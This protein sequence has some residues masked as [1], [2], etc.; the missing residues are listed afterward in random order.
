MDI[1]CGVFLRLPDAAVVPC[2][3]PRDH[4]ERHQCVVRG[5]TLLVWSITDDGTGRVSDGALMGLFRDG[6]Y[7][8]GEELA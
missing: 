5:L 2:T 7:P 8:R 3:M 1:L 4:L 6:L